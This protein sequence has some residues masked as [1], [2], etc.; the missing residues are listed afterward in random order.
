MKVTVGLSSYLFGARAD[1]ATEMHGNRE[2]TYYLGKRLRDHDVGQKFRCTIFPPK[3]KCPISRPQTLG[4]G[5]TPKQEVLRY[6]PR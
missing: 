5:L 3:P 6:V 4:A 1:E 2:K